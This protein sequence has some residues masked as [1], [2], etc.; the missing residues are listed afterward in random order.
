MEND[1]ENSMEET[2]RPYEPP[3]FR[4]VRLEVRTSVLSVCSL[5]VPV[6]PQP[7]GDPIFCQEPFVGCRDVI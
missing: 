6:S 5:S 2:K 1:M 3:V 4:K 7:P